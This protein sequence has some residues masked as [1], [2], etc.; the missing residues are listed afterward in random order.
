LGLLAANGLML[1][2]TALALI[3]VNIRLPKEEAA[4]IERF[5]DD[6]RHYQ[7]RTG[8]YFPRLS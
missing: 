1:V 3:L 7:A 4:L 8:R 5:G 2:G 6:Y